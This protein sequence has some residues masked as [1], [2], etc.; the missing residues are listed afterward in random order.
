MT[1]HWTATRGCGCRAMY[2]P[3]Y[4]LPLIA[5]C[6]SHGPVGPVIPDTPVPVRDGTYGAEVGLFGVLQMTRD[7]LGAR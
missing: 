3:I 4:Q 5:Y 1:A 6:A 7:T 2:H